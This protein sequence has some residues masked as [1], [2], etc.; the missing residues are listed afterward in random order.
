MS[1]V[2]PVTAMRPAAVVLAIVGSIATACAEP[3]SPPTSPDPALPA[4][5][6]PVPEAAP[7]PTGPSV[8]D[9]ETVAWLRRVSRQHAE[10]T[11][12]GLAD[13]A[14]V[15][16][17]SDYETEELDLL[18]NLPALRELTIWRDGEG[19]ADPSPRPAPTDAD[20]ERVA[21]LPLTTLTIGGWS[22][23]FTDDG[24]RH[25]A[26]HETL[27]RLRL[28]QAQNVSDA[29]MVHVASMKA[30]EALHISY[31]NVT[32]VGLAHLL[33]CPTLREVEYGWA[34]A[35]RESLRRFRAAHPDRPFLRDE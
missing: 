5:A 9:E 20:L 19:R 2:T 15:R 18:A 17:S 34:A 32:D 35:A 3:T 29:G 14:A 28:N 4:D 11:E 31:S 10:L 21:R 33:E 7:T 12:D 25:L 22:A 26:G 1:P 23:P 27:R 13:V 8:S 24:L 30:L 16:L 6:D